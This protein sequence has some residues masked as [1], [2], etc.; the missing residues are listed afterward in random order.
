MFLSVFTVGDPINKRIGI[1][2]IGLNPPNVCACPRTG[3][4]LINNAFR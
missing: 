2:L 1:P 3:H 4:E